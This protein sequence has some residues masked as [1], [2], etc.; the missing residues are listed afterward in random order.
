[1]R[2]RRGRCRLSFTDRFAALEAA[3]RGIHMRPLVGLR[4]DRDPGPAAQGVYGSTST[5]GS[6]RS[7][8]LLTF[9]VALTFTRR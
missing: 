3:Q 5:V 4:T 9:A 2:E 8:A 6:G 1:M 7:I